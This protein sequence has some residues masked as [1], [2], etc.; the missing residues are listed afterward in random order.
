LTVG[1]VYKEFGENARWYGFTEFGFGV[2]FAIGSIVLGMLTDRRGVRGVYPAILLAWS[3][4]G[5]LT[6]FA[7]GWPGLIFFRVLLG[8]VEAGHWPCGVRTTQTILPREQRGAGNSL[9]QSGAAVG[10]IL[11]PLVVLSLVHEPGTWRRPFWVIGTFGL[12]WVVAWL[13]LVRPRDLSA[14]HAPDPQEKAGPGA[15]ADWAFFGDRRFWVLVVVVTTINIAWHYFRAWL[16]LILAGLRYD[17]RDTLLFTS[18]YYV[19]ADLGSLAVGFGTLYLAR[20][21]AGVHRARVTGFVACTAL[22]CGCVVLVAVL[23]RGPGLLA[24]L[25][26]LGFASL[27]LFPNYYSFTQELTVRHQGRLTGTL[28]CITWLAVA[29]MQALVGDLKERTGSY[30]VGMLMAGLTPLA[31]AVALVLFWKE[32]PEAA[33]RQVGTKFGLKD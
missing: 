23:P 28:G 6:G 26:V 25:L 29:G 8:F 3:V 22:S 19:S 24:A 2:A 9:L 20:R 32:P 18:A 21:G 33:A 11:T 30:A 1:K 13:V 27:G 4:V 5:F 16:P 7:R 15:E 31:G 12:A 10:S 17:D 14:P